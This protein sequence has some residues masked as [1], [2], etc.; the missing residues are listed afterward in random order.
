MDSFWTRADGDGGG[1]GWVLLDDLI[2]AV[3][4]TG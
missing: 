1:W 3:T 4:D 2:Q